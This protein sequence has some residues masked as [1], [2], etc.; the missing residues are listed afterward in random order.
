MPGAA[1]VRGRAR[2]AQARTNQLQL[3][4]IV[5]IADLNF[6]LHFRHFAFRR[7]PTADRESE[8][9]PST[10]GRESESSPVP[11]MVNGCELLAHATQPAS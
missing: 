10:S 1:P 8:S 3:K 11:T 2:N 7:L 9:S 4:R 5:T 6:G